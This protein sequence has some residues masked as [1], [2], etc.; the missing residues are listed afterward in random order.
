MNRKE[1]RARSAVARR[2]KKK[3]DV[4]VA[5]VAK[6]IRAELHKLPPGLKNSPEGREEI[7]RIL[8]SRIAE[9]PADIQQPLRAV[10]DRR[11]WV[12]E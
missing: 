1:R 10:L 7:R 5:K 4:A 9:F 6:V 2:N 11:W 12:T 3:R 8:E